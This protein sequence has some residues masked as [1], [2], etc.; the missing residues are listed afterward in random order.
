MRSKCLFALAIIATLSFLTGCAFTVH[1]TPLN[2]TYSGK[3]PPQAGK[4][5]AK[6]LTLTEIKDTRDVT[7]PRMIAHKRNGHGYQTSGGWEAE[8]PIADIVKDALSEGIKQR[9]L[10]LSP[11]ADVSLSG[12]LMGFS[13]WWKHPTPF[14]GVFNSRMAVKLQ[15]RDENSKKILWRETFVGEATIEDGDYVKDG[16]TSALNDLVA[17]VVTDEFFLQQLE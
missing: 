3:L 4:A 8:R 13:G 2:Y 14:H 11:K 10:T 12:E 16:F 9:G 6:S 7:T 1:D 5:P 15:L 17:K